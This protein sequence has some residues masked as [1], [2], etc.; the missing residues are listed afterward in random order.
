MKCPK[1][2]GEFQT[3]NDT[4]LENPDS[5]GYVSDENIKLVTR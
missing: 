3:D 5:V 4:P 2:G 1:Y